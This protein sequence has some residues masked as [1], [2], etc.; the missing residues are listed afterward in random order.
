MLVSG[1]VSL[2][3]V[4]LPPSN[5]PRSWF[6]HIKSSKAK[7]QERKQ[8]NKWA[9][10]PDSSQKIKCEWLKNTT[11]LAV[12]KMQIESMF[13]LYLSPIRLLRE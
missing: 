9:K 7:E 6:P 1:S 10:G 13:A 3:L 11:T 12:R 8:I 2:G 4:T 5:L